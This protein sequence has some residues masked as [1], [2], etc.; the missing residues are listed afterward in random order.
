MSVISKTLTDGRVVSVPEGTADR[1]R[2]IDAEGDLLVE[3]DFAPVG[4]PKNFLY[5]LTPCCRASSKGLFDENDFSPYVGCRHCYG[6]VD[7]K[8]G[9]VFTVA[10]I[11][12]A[13]AA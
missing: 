13:V 11:A 1:F 12:A 10:D 2:G 5:A 3:T 4:D 9:G 7:P 6:E 8:F